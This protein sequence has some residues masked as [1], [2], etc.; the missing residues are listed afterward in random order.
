AAGTMLH[1]HPVQV[2]A[3][4]FWPVARYLVVAIGPLAIALCAGLAE[5]LPGRWRGLA[6]GAGL[7]GLVTLD[8]AALWTVILPYYY[9]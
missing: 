3:H 6:G 2:L 9:G 5:L 1:I 8:V 4:V 7:L